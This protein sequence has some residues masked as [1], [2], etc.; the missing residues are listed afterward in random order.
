MVLQLSKKPC[1]ETLQFGPR[2]LGSHGLDVCRRKPH[3]S[4]LPGAMIDLLAV[5]HEGG[6]GGAGVRGGRLDHLTAARSQTDA[7]GE[8]KGLSR[9]GRSAG[10]VGARG[11]SRRLGRGRF[12][13]DRSTPVTIFLAAIGPT[14]NACDSLQESFS[15]VDRSARLWTGRRSPRSALFHS[16]ARPP[17]TS[18]AARP[19]PSNPAAADSQPTDTIKCCIPRPDCQMEGP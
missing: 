4:E 3:R 9:P 5:V 16:R 7:K 10:T 17:R 12:G 2:G 13:A 14:V 6:R 1:A 18:G 19:P 8:E 15:R 11:R